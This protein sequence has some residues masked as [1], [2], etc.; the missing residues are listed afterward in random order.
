M[1]VISRSGEQTLG[2]LFDAYIPW[3]KFRPELGLSW[4]AGELDGKNSPSAVWCDSQVHTGSHMEYLYGQRT[5]PCRGS[6]YGSCYH[7][8]GCTSRAVNELY[9]ACCIHELQPPQAVSAFEMN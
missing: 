1:V 8:K 4:R 6:R 2:R 9:E 5:R 3:R 7:I